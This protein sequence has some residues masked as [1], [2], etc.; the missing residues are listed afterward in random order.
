MTMRK[1]SSVSVSG[2]EWVGYR[3]SSVYVDDGAGEGISGKVLDD[4]AVYQV[5]E[6]GENVIHPA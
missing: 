5:C 6:L 4:R 3:R 1:S 2:R